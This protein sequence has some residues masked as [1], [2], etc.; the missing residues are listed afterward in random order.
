MKI[1]LIA[2][3]VVLLVLYCWK[4]GIINFEWGH[5][6]KKGASPDVVDEA[7]DD[8]R[9]ES[10]LDVLRRLC[11]ERG[12][13][14]SIEASTWWGRKNESDWIMGVA[15]PKGF[16][17]WWNESHFFVL[18]ATQLMAVRKLTKSISSGDFS[19]V[20]RKKPPAIRG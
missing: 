19:K 3:A 7:C 8:V 16:D 1:Y 15:W 20:A 14:F 18:G 5:K 9:L 13:Q 4:A 10:A 6:K 2:I 11:T 12:L 17:M